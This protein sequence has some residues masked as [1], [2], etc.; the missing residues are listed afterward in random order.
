[1]R[2][3]PS[4]GAGRILSSLVFGWLMAVTAVIVVVNG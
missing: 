4:F 3:S 1:M 2:V